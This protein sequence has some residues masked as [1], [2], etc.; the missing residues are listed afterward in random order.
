MNKK[1]LELKNKRAAKVTE[2]KAITSKAEVEKRVKSP[3]ELVQWNELKTEIEDFDAELETLEFEERQNKGV[4]AEGINSQQESGEQ[5]EMKRYNLSKAILELRKGG[6]YTG[7]EREMQDEAEKELRQLGQESTGLVISKKL[8]RTMTKAANTGHH[9][10]LQAGLDVIADRGLLASLG[11]TQY[12]GLTSQM[13]LVFGNGFSAN[14]VGEGAAA[15]QTPATEAT[16]KIEPKRIQGWD[17]FSNEFLAQAATMPTLL[18]DMLG[19][20]ET[21]AAKRIMDDIIAL[22][23]LTGHEKTV[24][25]AL[26]TWKNV[27]KLKGALKTTQ[28][29]S[30]KFV[31]GGELYASMEATTKDA[32]SGRYLIEAGKISAYD[33]VDA[34]GLIAPHN[35]GGTTPEDRYQLIFG[36]FSRAYLGFY[37]GMEILVDPFTNSNAGQT[38]LTWHRLGDVAV[39]PKAFTSIQNA[40]L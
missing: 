15:G 21:A 8:L 26:L 24:A 1:I 40:K 39:N 34:Q 27:M 2:L 28:L 3:E 19:S 11:V 13:K 20:I 35:S 9:S 36:D 30:P 32:G 5:K 22:P 31:A 6:N 25:A 4:A 38:K 10:D 12:D 29:K 16:G 37:S 14:F 18:A 23:A 17:L 33:S 7:F